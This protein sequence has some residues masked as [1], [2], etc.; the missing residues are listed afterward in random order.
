MS[1]ILFCKD[2]LAMFQIFAVTIIVTMIAETKE[3][4]L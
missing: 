1:L 4:Q 3:L 2:W